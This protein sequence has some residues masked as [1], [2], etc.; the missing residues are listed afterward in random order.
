MD[1]DPV[2]DS[3]L[4]HYTRKRLEEDDTKSPK[5]LTLDHMTPGVETD[6]NVVLR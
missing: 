6:D 3:F 4:C 1:Y 2:T 5:C